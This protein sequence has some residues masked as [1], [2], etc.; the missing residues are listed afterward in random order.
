MCGRH[1]H[2][3]CEVRQ[4]EEVK[5]F[6]CTSKMAEYGQNSE[7]RLKNDKWSINPPHNPTGEMTNLGQT[8]QLLN[9]LII[10]P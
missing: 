3:L 4:K 1:Q 2:Q 8:A 10:N 9:L 7:E 5:R 6:Y